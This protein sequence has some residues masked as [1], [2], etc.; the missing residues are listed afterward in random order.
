MVADAN[1]QRTREELRAK[2][3]HALLALA[4]DFYSAAAI[5]PDGARMASALTPQER[6]ICGCVAD[7]MRNKD[8][9]A[10]LGLSTETVKRHLSNISNK[11]G[12]DTRLEIAVAVLTRPALFA[13]VS[14]PSQVK[15]CS[16]Q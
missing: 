6:V 9:A 5:D 12:M 4:D 7:A 3:E 1:V 11:L 2:R 13:A 10:R 14:I 15:P 8:I 16:Q